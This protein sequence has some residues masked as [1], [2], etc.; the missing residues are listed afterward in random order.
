MKPKVALV[1]ASKGYQQVEY[2][3]TKKVLE[4]N[5]YQ[6]VTVSD[7]AGTATAKDNTTTI[8]NLTLNQLKVADYTGIFFIGGPGA[9]ERLD[10]QISYSILRDAKARN[11]VRG[12]ICVA[13]RI[14]AHAGILDGLEATGWNGDNELAK[15]YKE[16]N[17]TYAPV[18]VVVCDYT[19][20]ATGPSA[21]QEF[22]EA[23]VNLLNTQTN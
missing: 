7:T 14:L 20:T 8:V 6:V 3:E 17:V 18:A 5:N 12:A 22:G 1:I 2:S 13:T 10:T 19:I 15:I 16:Y 9:L 23:I 4:S 11:V 21:A